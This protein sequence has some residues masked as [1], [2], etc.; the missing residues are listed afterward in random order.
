M[1][2]GCGDRSRCTR[3]AATFSEERG[4]EQAAVT[5]AT[6]TADRGKK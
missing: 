4:T 2:F 5:I 1:R 6:V 3:R